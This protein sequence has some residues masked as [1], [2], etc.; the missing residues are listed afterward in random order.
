MFHVVVLLPWNDA[1]LTKVWVKKVLGVYTKQQHALL[2]WDTFSG[3]MTEDVQAELQKQNVS[4]V[5]IPG[6]CTSK[7]Q[8]LDVCLNK[9]F[10]SYCHA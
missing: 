10:K 2:I 6:G 3:H 7:I 4:A 9:P 8:P 1:T 5:V